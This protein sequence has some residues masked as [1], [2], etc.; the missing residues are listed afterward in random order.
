M[1]SS[2]AAIL[3]ERSVPEATD[4]ERFDLLYEQLKYFHDRALDAV[5]NVTAALLLVTGWV[6]TS[7]N[8]RRILASDRTSRWLSLLVVILYGALYV[9]AAL[10][11]SRRSAQ[12]ARELD[13]IA[14]MPREHYRG[15]EVPF[16]VAMMFI[17]MNSVLCLALIIFIVGFGSSS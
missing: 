9:A 10:R 8:T 7:D 16:P 17:V 1:I 3:L 6:A 11:T 5:F 14:Y 4:K 12:V 2:L 15:L 13:A